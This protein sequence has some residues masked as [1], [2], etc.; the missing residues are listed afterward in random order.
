MLSCSGLFENSAKWP[1]MELSITEFRILTLL[2]K[3]LFDT[4]EP[5]IR[6]PAPIDTCG[7]M[8]ER[9]NSTF[10]PIKHG[11]IM[12]ELSFLTEAA[13]MFCSL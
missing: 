12:S 7:P 9:I 1:I 2:C 4:S 13:T 8:I 11:G 3:M 5:S 10:S 6:D